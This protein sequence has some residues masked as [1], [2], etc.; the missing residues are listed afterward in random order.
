LYDPFTLYDYYW[1]WKTYVPGRDSRL[2]DLLGAKYLLGKKDITLPKGKF[3]LVFDGDKDLNVYE[4]PTALPRAFFVSGA[5]AAPSHDAALAAI[6]DPQFDPSRTVVVEGSGVTSVP[7]SAALV[8]GQFLVDGPN[9]VS[10]KVSAPGN[11][12]LV[13]TDP[14]YGGWQAQ[15]DGRPATLYRADWAFRAVALGPGEHVVTFRFR[16]TSL[17]AFGVVSGL[18]WLAAVALIVWRLIPRKQPVK[19]VQRRPAVTTA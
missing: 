1:L 12:Y 14:Y 16:P 15:V 3:Q 2:Y 5:Q 4:N 7:A 8:A 10:V 18:G 6:R 19:D 17:I 9:T 13:L 11:G